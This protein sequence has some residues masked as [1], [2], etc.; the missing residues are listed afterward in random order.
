MNK[1]LSSNKVLTQLYL[2]S[3]AEIEKANLQ[4]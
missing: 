4:K 1:K 3:K 2:K